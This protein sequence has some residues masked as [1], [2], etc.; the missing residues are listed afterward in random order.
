MGLLLL[1]GFLLA[2]CTPL[3]GDAVEKEGQKE[4]KEQKEK[5]SMHQL[6]NGDTYS[7]DLSD[8]VKVEYSHVLDEPFSL[9]PINLEIGY[10]GMRSIERVNPDELEEL[11]HYGYYGDGPFRF[12]LFSYSVENPSDLPVNSPWLISKVILSTGEQLDVTTMNMMPWGQDQFYGDSYVNNI[13]IVV[14]FTSDPEDIDSLRIITGEVYDM[15]DDVV[16]PP[17]EKEFRLD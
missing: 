7:N 11:S 4:S 10:V 6:K 3:E 2:A 12:L 16:H 17:D 14:P 13:E 9:G 8:E 15:D 1:C 5:K